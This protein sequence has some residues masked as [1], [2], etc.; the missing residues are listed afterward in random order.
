MDINDLVRL[1]R[2][3]RPA[4]R[5]RLP[6]PD[7]D[8]SRDILPLLAAG[9]P[10]QNN[11]PKFKLLSGSYHCT[12][13]K[14]LLD[15]VADCGVHKYPYKPTYHDCPDF[16]FALLGKFC[17]EPEW[18][19]TA[20]GVCT[21]MSDAGWHSLN[22]A[23]CYPDEVSRTPILCTIEPQTAQPVYWALGQPLDMVLMP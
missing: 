10:G 23:V 6:L 18:W 22:I 14:N 19:G 1:F 11:I 7:L 5:C 15:Y 3:W 12:T 21:V 17:N 9:W 8:S 13:I 16:A 2:F 4:I 20:L